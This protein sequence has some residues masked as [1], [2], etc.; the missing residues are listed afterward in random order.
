MMA[1]ATTINPRGLVSQP[2]TFPALFRTGEF[3]A[4]IEYFPISMAAMI[5]SPFNDGPSRRRRAEIP[6]PILAKTGKV[7]SSQ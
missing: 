3:L 4:G 2:R 6:H 5:P 1:M 7:S